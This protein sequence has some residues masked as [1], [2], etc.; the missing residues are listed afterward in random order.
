M[1]GQ[2]FD[3]LTKAL[4]GTTPS[5]RGVLRGLAGGA[6]AAVFGGT[7]FGAAAQVGTTEF[8]LTCRQQGVKF[9][10]NDPAPVTECGPGNLGCRCARGRESG[11]FCIE[12][13]T[14]GCPSKSERCR[15]NSDCRSNEVCVSIRDCCP[16]NPGRGKC[17][18]RCNE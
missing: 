6:F 4:A 17:V 2:R 12:Q 11:R 16:D 10:C 1:D 14:G 3:D 5:R 13:P 8:D 7:A 15:Q 18:R 9:Y